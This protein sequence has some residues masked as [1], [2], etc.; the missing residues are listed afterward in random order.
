MER[1]YGRHHLRRLEDITMNVKDFP[2]VSTRANQDPPHRAMS[3]APADHNVAMTL[4]GCI[5]AATVLAVLWGLYA[6]G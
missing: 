3:R 2:H 6:F 1:Q 4:L 5:A